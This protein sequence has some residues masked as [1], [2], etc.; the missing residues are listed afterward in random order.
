MGVTGFISDG[1]LFLF[2]NGSSLFLPSLQGTFVLVSISFVLS[3]T[4]SLLWWEVGL[5]LLRKIVETREL[6]VNNFFFLFSPFFFEFL[7]KESSESVDNEPF[8]QTVQ[9]F[10]HP[11]TLDEFERNKK[12]QTQN[13]V[14]ALLNHMLRTDLMDSRQNLKTLIVRFVLLA[15]LWYLW[16]WGSKFLRATDQILDAFVAVLMTVLLVFYGLIPLLSHLKLLFSIRLNHLWRMFKSRFPFLGSLASKAI[17]LFPLALLITVAQTTIMREESFE[18]MS[19]I[20]LD[21]LKTMRVI[22]SLP[23]ISGF[24]WVP[25]TQ[26]W[27]VIPVVQSVVLAALF[28]PMVTFWFSLAVS[29]FVGFSLA[30]LLAE[31]LTVKNPYFS[32]GC[33]VAAM[34]LVF[35]VICSFKTAIRFSLLTIVTVVCTIA[36]IMTSEHSL[37]YFSKEI[38]VLFPFVTYSVRALPVMACAALLARSIINSSLENGFSRVVSGALVS[39]FLFVGFEGLFGAQNLGYTMEMAA[40]YNVKLIDTAIL[41]M[42]IRI[43]RLM[44]L[45]Q[46]KNEI[47]ERRARPQKGQDDVYVLYTSLITFGALFSVVVDLVHYIP[48]IQLDAQ[49]TALYLAVVLL[50]LVFF[51]FDTFKASLFGD[52]LAL[53]IA[54]TIWGFKRDVQH[55]RLDIFQDISGKSLWIFFSFL[56]VCTACYLWYVYKDGAAW[57]WKKKVNLLILCLAIF[58]APTAMQSQDQMSLSRMNLHPRQEGDVVRVCAFS[59]AGY[60]VHVERVSRATERSMI[61]VSRGEKRNVNDSSAALLSIMEHLGTKASV[62]VVQLDSIT[63]EDH[64]MV[65]IGYCKEQNVDLVYIPALY[66]VEKELIGGMISSLSRAASLL[67]KAGIVLVSPVGDMGLS[68]TIGSDVAAPGNHEDAISVGGVTRIGDTV[69]FAQK[70]FKERRRVK[71]TNAKPEVSASIQWGG[72]RSTDI[73]A[74]YVAVALVQC[75]QSTPLFRKQGVEKLSSLMKQNKPAQGKL[76]RVFGSVWSFVSAKAAPNVNFVKRA[77]RDSLCHPSDDEFCQHDP[78]KGFGELNE[79]KL[80]EKLLE[81]HNNFQ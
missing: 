80:C 51:S 70:R 29:G 75:L 33:A 9:Q 45:V 32:L 73:S 50:R 43:A 14:S 10:A 19:G 38:F 27:L 25:Y 12:V 42:M 4:L 15:G 28:F 76:K 7:S 35:L 24:M 44:H 78:Y 34:T 1:L 18:L 26:S 63:T 46:V 66:Q 56:L 61:H 52:V 64:L 36:I 67:S 74:A 22:V 57:T 60:G 41:D 62:Y 6:E 3:V 40:L 37:D 20:A 39:M 17:Q 81:Y 68:S 48:N 13:A 49:N 5:K 77:L 58:A 71:E 53:I 69:P 11:V 21:G 59:N 65:A 16:F 30:P 31:M 79:E 23:Y 72:H 8:E 2:W 47:E 55:I 54:A